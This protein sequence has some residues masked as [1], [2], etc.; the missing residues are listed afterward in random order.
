MT[1]KRTFNIPAA[2]HCGKDDEEQ[3]NYEKLLTILMVA[4]PLAAMSV[5][6]AY[7]DIPHRRSNGWQTPWHK[8]ENMLKYLPPSRQGEF[9][10][11]LQGAY[12]QL[13]Y[14]AAKK[15]LKAIKAE[16]GKLNLSAVNSLEDA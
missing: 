13:T 6:E 11:K 2:V 16:F 7:R 1:S 12:E 14:E 4:A 15:S 9:R 8:R 3:R 5:E 10:R